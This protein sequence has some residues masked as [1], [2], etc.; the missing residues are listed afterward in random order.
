MANCLRAARR[1]GLTVIVCDRPNPIGG[2]EVEGPTLERG[3]E[4]FVGQFAIPMRHWDDHR[5]AR[6]AVQRTLRHRRR[7]R[8]GDD[9]GMVSRSVLG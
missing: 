8:G 7:P 9:G 3:F 1:H 6:A 2:I 5:R 4:S